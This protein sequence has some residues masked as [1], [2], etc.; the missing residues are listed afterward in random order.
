MCVSEG[1]GWKAHRQEDDVFNVG[2]E[3][4][5]ADALHPVRLFVEPVQGNRYVVRSEVPKDIE[6][7]LVN[8]EIHSLAVDV[9][10]GPKHIPSKQIAHGLDGRVVDK[11]VPDHQGS[12]GELARAK[13]RL[14]VFDR[15][16]ERLFNKDVLSVGECLFGQATVRADRGRD[17]YRLDR[18]IGEYCAVICRDPDRRITLRDSLKPRRVKIGDRDD[19]GPRCLGERSNQV[20]PPV[21][22]SDDG[23][24]QN[25]VF[26][27]SR[28]GFPS[29][30]R[31]GRTLANRR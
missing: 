26:E 22:C 1:A 20:R 16:G 14:G 13:D 23:N 2:E 19:L 7:E 28:H 9:A 29:P 15:S 12:R 11:C 21:A 8:P 5:S 3:I 24:P 4:R 10:N 17:A 6:V 27:G 25:L 18:A 30:P 31:A